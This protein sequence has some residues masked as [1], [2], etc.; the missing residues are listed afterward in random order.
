MSE[1]NE[2][3]L[4]FF[5]ER[6][7][8]LALLARTD[9]TPPD[10]YDFRE[11][12]YERL[13]PLAH[14][15]TSNAPIPEPALANAIDFEKVANTEHTAQISFSFFKN[16]LER[17]GLGSAEGQG[18]IATNA[19]S[20]YCFK[21]VTIA[22]VSVIDVEGAL[23]AGLANDHVA[24][25]VKSG[26]IHIAY[27]YIYAGKVQI[28]RGHHDDMAVGLSANIPQVAKGSATSSHL[29]KNTS[30][31]SYQNSVKPVVIAFKVGQLVKS[32]TEWKLK[33]R[34]GS[35]GFDPSSANSSHYVYRPGEILTVQ[36]R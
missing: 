24:S 29:G 13:G 35:A 20:T 7:Y 36:D 9:L 28:S 22:S 25:Q 1:E 8:Q 15:L 32:G 17:F 6:G 33:T 30:L 34:R 23:R 26:S 11:G 5:N 21:D 27:E 16:L 14:F 31:I 2:A 3:L 4:R 19:E 12:S 10:V 18:K